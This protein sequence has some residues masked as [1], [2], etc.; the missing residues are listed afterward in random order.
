MTTRWDGDDERS[1]RDHRVDIS[2][3]WGTTVPVW[4]NWGK[5]L[6]KLQVELPDVRRVGSAIDPAR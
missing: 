3:V 2:M 4:L 1:A 6:M 5:V